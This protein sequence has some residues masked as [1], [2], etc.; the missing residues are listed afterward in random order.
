MN[1]QQ[2]TSGAV[3]FSEIEDRFTASDEYADRFA[4]PVGTFFLEVQTAMTLD[5]LRDMAGATVLDVGGGHGQLAVPLVK[6][7]FQVTVTGSDDNCRQ[8]LD[9][10]LSPDTFAY[11]T[12]DCLHLPFSDRS[13]D[14]VLSFRLLP[15]VTAWRPLL[16]E[17]G[18][19][20]D[21]MV[22]FDYPDI[23]SFNILYRLFFRLKKSLEGNTRT[24]TL[25][26]RSQ[27]GTVLREAGFPLQSYRP[28][29]F[30]PMVLHRKTGNATLARALEGMT[31]FLGLT[32]LV[33]SPII[34]RAE[35]IRR[36]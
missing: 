36:D 12:C 11:Q 32:R 18:R 30:W 35:R 8:R 24:Y 25:F 31:R 19:V 22:L 29:F 10:F 4:G 9:R 14:V 6:K 5:L 33:G 23:R 15:H 3:R 16:R 34:V 2:A 26:S 1:G 28:E 7:G 13:F 27:I 21:R 20:A 17:M